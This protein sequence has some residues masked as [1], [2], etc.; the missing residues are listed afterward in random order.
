MHVLED[1]A[2]SVQE[3][4]DLLKE[5]SESKGVIPNANAMHIAFRHCFLKSAS[6]CAEKNCFEAAN[7]ALCVM[8]KHKCRFDIKTVAEIAMSISLRADFIN[9]AVF[10]RRLVRKTLTHLSENERSFVARHMIFALAER[11]E[12]ADESLSRSGAFAEKNLRIDW[13]R[14][15]SQEFYLYNK[16]EGQRKSYN[17]VEGYGFARK[18]LVGLLSMELDVATQQRCEYK[19]QRDGAIV[20]IVKAEE[21][22]ALVVRM[23]TQVTI[24]FR[25]GVMY[26]L[27]DMDVG[28][29]QVKRIMDALRVLGRDPQYLRSMPNPYLCQMLYLPPE[30][31]YIVRIALQPKVAPLAGELELNEYGHEPIRVKSIGVGALLQWNV[32]N[33]NKTIRVGDRILRVNEASD[34]EAILEELQHAHQWNKYDLKVTFMRKVKAHENNIAGDELLPNAQDTQVVFGMQEDILADKLN[35]S[36][37]SA[38]SVA[39]TRRLSLIQG[40]PGTGKTTTAVEL[41]VFLLD[42]KIVPTPILVSGHTNA[43]VDNILIGLAKKGRRVVRIGDHNKVRVDCKP[44]VLGEECA[45]EPRLA[46]VICATCSGSG[47]AVFQKENIKCHT[48]LIDEGSQATESSCLIPL[49]HAAQHLVIVGDQCQLEP[50][51]KS[52]VAKSDNLGTSLFN[53]LCQQG[54]VPTMLNVQY[55]MHPSICEFPS[56]AFYNGQLLAGVGHSD[57]KPTSYWQWPSRRNPVCF[58]DAKDGVEEASDGKMEKKN[59]H[60]VSLV[61]S[62]LKEL[63]R[64]AEMRSICEDGTYPV[65]IVTPYAAQK[66]TIVEEL[67]RAGFLDANG[68]H[69]IETNSVDGFQGREKEVIIFSAVRANDEGSVGFLHDWRRINVMLTRAKRGLIIIGNRDTLQTDFYWSNWLKWAAMRG[70]IMGESAHGN[71]T[72]KCLVEDEWIMRPGS[73]A[74][75]CSFPR[76]DAMQSV[77]NPSSVPCQAKVQLWLGEKFAVD[78]VES[79]EEFD[80]CSEGPAEGDLEP[81]EASF[82]TDSELSTFGTAESWEDHDTSSM[83]GPLDKLIQKGNSAD[84]LIETWEDLLASSVRRANPVDVEVGNAEVVLEKM[85]PQGALPSQEIGFDHTDETDKQQLP[86]L[87][88]IFS[89]EAAVEQQELVAGSAALSALPA[90]LV[91]LSSSFSPMTL[92]ALLG[93]TS[94]LEAPS[95]SSLERLETGNWFDQSAYHSQ[96]HCAETVHTHAPPQTTPES[97]GEMFVLWMPMLMPLPMTMID[98]PSYQ[99]A[100]FVGTAPDGAGPAEQFCELWNCT[101]AAEQLSGSAGRTAAGMTSS[102]DATSHSY[103]ILWHADARKLYGNDRSLVSPAF[104]LCWDQQ[105]TAF[106]KF[107]LLAKGNGFAK[108]RGMGSVALKCESDLRGVGADLTFSITVGSDT[109]GPVSHDFSSHSTAYLQKLAMSFRS[110]EDSSTKTVPI[111]LEIQQT[112]RSVPP[113]EDAREAVAEPCNVASDTMCADMAQGTPAEMEDVRIRVSRSRSEVGQQRQQARRQLRLEERSK[114]H[115][116]LDN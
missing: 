93:E 35:S 51:V 58:I 54:I 80:T 85:L 61:L 105:S 5:F 28:D 116:V 81:S 87:S 40:P 21:G 10:L 43:A 37:L 78:A 74:S 99:K 7:F 45:A 29:L 47:S 71:W 108:S 98:A 39:A 41:L 91:D 76:Q 109:R 53:R 57:R 12:A 102:F 90:E 107:M 69:L 75:S 20:D 59:L 83:C 89:G 103:H 6:F 2:Y 14:S 94:P 8:E 33:P 111:S 62:V 101:T 65:G 52:D 25:E 16:S 114:K 46:E 9:I 26:R 55:R 44:F 82:C 95:A 50:F 38:V 27:D 1:A 32:K 70:C 42:H 96:W 100:A 106:F 11:K 77:L 34:K 36:Q 97:A 4:Y 13:Q 23:R 19:A 86:G 67:A 113:A 17:P 49:C 68:Q 15:S 18:G 112:L 56:A 110:E 73:V 60:E 22:E 24:P 66:Q 84:A 104:E 72:A 88:T 92:E 48:V 3:V 115:V 79:W 31:P 64:D 63:L 30:E